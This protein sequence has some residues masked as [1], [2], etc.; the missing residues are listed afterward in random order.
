MNYSRLK[1]PHPECGHICDILTKAHV[2]MEHDME[3]DELFELYGEPIQLRVDGKTLSENSR[4]R[5]ISA[6]PLNG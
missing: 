6:K 4:I 1:C 3:R 2:R 5:T